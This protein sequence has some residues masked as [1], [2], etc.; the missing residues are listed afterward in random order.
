MFER[1][2]RVWLGATNT[3]FLYPTPS[4]CSLIYI[5]T[6]NRIFP[7][8]HLP[9]VVIQ[10]RLIAMVLLFYLIFNRPSCA[11]DDSLLAEQNIV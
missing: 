7:H 6:L 5:A 11:L 3:L 1:V 8:S 4:A 10:L 9:A 2:T